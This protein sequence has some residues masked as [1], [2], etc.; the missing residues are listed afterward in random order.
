MSGLEDAGFLTTNSVANFVLAKR[1]QVMP[2]VAKLCDDLM[3][4][5]VIIRPLESFGL[6]GHVGISVGTKGEIEHLFQALKTINLA[7]EA[8]S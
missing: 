6:K 5:G 7:C 8:G 4:L 2:P 1:N 3:E